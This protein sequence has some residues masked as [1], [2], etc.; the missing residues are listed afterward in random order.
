MRAV[1][2]RV[3]HANVAVD[4]TVIAK[5]GPGLMILLGITHLDT[6]Q[7]VIW[8]VNKINSLRIFE[9]HEGKMNLG[10][11]E[12]QGEVLVISQFTLYGD[13]TKGRRPGFS[14][15]A[16]PETAIPLY[17]KYLELSRVSGIQTKC[18]KFGAH[19]KVELLNDGPV[20]LLIDTKQPEKS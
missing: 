10:L 9:D 16:R 4:G 13:C 20:T 15:A 7:D 11:P 18:G 5:I 19:M 17:E 6:E 2:Q 14:E 12:I 1:V 8:L 3:C